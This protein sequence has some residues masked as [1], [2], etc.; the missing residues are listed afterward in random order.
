MPSSVPISIPTGTEMVFNLDL[1]VSKCPIIASPS[2]ANIINLMSRPNIIKVINLTLT[3][4]A[5]DKVS[6]N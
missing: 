2:K 4:N 5:T 1:K 3:F 6:S